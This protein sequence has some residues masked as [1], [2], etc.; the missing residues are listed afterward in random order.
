MSLNFSY[1]L[2]LSPYALAWLQWIKGGCKKDD[3]INGAMQF[4]RTANKLISEGFVG[5]T[6]DPKRDGRAANYYLTPAG[7]KLVEMIE[8]Q[9]KEMAKGGS[10]AGLLP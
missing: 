6:N 5:H 8:L 4:I 2:E 1:K 7:V 10:D 9:Y 3:K